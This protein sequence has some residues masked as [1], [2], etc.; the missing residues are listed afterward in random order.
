MPIL[1]QLMV[2]YNS[3]KNSANTIHYPI[4]SVNSIF[5]IPLI[6]SYVWLTVDK[7]GCLAMKTTVLYVI[8]MCWKINTSK[9]FLSIY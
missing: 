1:L 8:L 6:F 4:Y 2:V 5:N 7:Y 3:S 9:M